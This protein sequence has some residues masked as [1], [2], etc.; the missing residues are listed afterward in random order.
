MAEASN[1][2][3][4]I[5]EEDLAAG[6]IKAVQTRFPPEPNGYLH[7]GHAKSMYVNF[8]IAEK[9]GGKCNL[10]Y[11][12]T[13]PS[14]EKTE[15][16]DAIKRDIAWLGYHW[17]KEVYASDFF[18]TI[19]EF[20]EKLILEGKAFVCDLSAE[21]I[22]ETRGTLTEPGTE[23]PCRN[24]T[25]EENLRL[26]REMRAGKYADGEK[27]LRAKIDMA[28]PNVNLRDPVIY[29]ILR[30][31]HH[32]TGDKWCIYPMYDYAHPICDYLQGVTHSL[33][34][35]EFEDHRPL[36]D[37]VGIN[38]GFD[39]KPRQIEF[40]RLNMTNLVMSKRYLKKLV[41]D[42][43]VHGWDDPRMPTLAGLR[44]RGIPAAAVRDF[45]ERAGVAKAQSECDISYFEAVV[46][47][48]LNARAP[49]AMAVVDPLK[50]TVTNYEGSEEIDFEV[51]Q[52][53]PGAGTRKVTFGKHLYIE[54]GD[55]S[56]D[57]PPKYHRLKIGGVARLKN[58]YIVRCD[59]A[60]TDENGNVT[61]ILCTYLPESRSGHDTSGVKAKGVLHWVNADVCEDAVLKQYDHLLKDAD[62]AGQDFSERMNLDSEHL[63]SAK[64]EPYL[65]QAQEGTAFQLMRTGYYKVCRD[66]GKLCLS[67][68]VSL[69]DNFNK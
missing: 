3:E 63:F 43:S 48:Y 27:C 56:L 42:G 6:R 36:Y 62:Y 18:D 25:P 29:R 16:V 4:Q 14:K 58:A 53:D 2:I 51:N 54:R 11:D 15:F 45:C 22:R 38:L 24:R 7:I 40:A 37:W 23:S 49:R 10:F 59:E 21:Q 60:V 68:I 19:Y 17:A 13:N 20:A 57:P 33:C 8:G 1:F 64:A 32:R 69:K 44:N 35:L 46:R 67:E 28:S 41:E 9:F 66:Q 39:P 34:T 12:D 31:T 55:F 30:A 65:A 61:E 52:L 5:I 50:L 26:F 47:D